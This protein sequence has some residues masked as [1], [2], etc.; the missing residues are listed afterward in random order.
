[1]IVRSMPLVIATRM[2]PRLA[3]RSK[4]C[5]AFAGGEREARYPFAGVIDPGAIIQS[6]G[7]LRAGRSPLPR[8]HRALARL[9]ACQR[10]YARL[11][12]QAVSLQ[13]LH[14]HPG[15]APDA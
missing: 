6:D 12:Q 1:V 11:G 8:P 9:R 14:G 13:G 15:P 4:G 2:P 7:E 5:G 10:P 3:W